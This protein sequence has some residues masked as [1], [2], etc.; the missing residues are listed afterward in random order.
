MWPLMATSTQETTDPLEI[1]VL[2]KG[3]EAEPYVVGSDVQHAQAA[4]RTAFARQECI[5]VMGQGACG[6]IT[7]EGDISINPDHNTKT[8]QDALKYLLTSAGYS[9]LREK[10][11][12]LLAAQEKEK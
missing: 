8:A 10:V 11:Q 1:R 6:H 2:G 9:V 7:P 3:T 5:Y 12:E 4:C